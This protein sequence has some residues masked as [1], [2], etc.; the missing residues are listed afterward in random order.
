MMTTFQPIK[1]S[2]LK[3]KE[4]EAYNF[5]KVSAI[6]A[7]L[8]FVTIRMS[9]DWGGADFI[10]QHKDGLFIKVQ[11]KG[12][13]TFS[14]KYREQKIYICF[15]DRKSD[16]WYLYPHDKLLNQVL[17]KGFLSDTESW[18]QKKIYHFSYVKPDFKKLLRPYEL[19]IGQ[20]FTLL[21][22]D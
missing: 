6:L 15:C 20:S 8:G 21:V 2:E 7:D 13:L 9:S 18:V 16:I 11:L 14:E 19:K 22:D 10:A 12:R 17:S 3:P 4:Q 1:Y 5:Q